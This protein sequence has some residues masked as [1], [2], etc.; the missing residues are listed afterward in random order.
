MVRTVVQYTSATVYTTS[1]VPILTIV[2]E[3]LVAHWVVGSLW[4][5]LL[6]LVLM[7]AHR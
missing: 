7:L 2:L 3:Y 1:T 6:L 4:L 5:L